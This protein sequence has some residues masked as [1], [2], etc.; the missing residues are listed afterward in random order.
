MA[1]VKVKVDGFAPRDGEFVTYSFNRTIDEYG[2]TTGKPQGGIVTVRVK[3]LVADFQPELLSWM[4]QGLEKKGSIEFEED[5]K[6]IKSLE[7]EK[8]FCINFKEEWTEKVGWWEEVTLTCKTLKMKQVEYN[9]E[10]WKK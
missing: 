6:F 10:G 3:A 9:N 5:G 7:F 1:T 8:A 4:T 2:Q